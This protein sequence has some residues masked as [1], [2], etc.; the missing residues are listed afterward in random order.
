LAVPL[1]LPN[2]RIHEI[3]DSNCCKAPIERWRLGWYAWRCAS[4]NAKHNYF[5]AGGHE[6]KRN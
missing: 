5:P 3:Q 1:S 6:W 2:D 4:H